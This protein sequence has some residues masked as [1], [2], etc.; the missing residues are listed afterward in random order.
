MDRYLNGKTT[1]LG[2]ISIFLVL[3]FTQAL[4]DILSVVK[5]KDNTTNET[6]ESHRVMYAITDN[7]NKRLERIDVCITSI[8]KTLASS[9]EIQ[10]QQGDILRTQKELLV[11]YKYILEEVKGI[12]VEL[13]RAKG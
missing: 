9:L 5:G 12:L 10:R 2:I 1:A 6:M 8:D 13:K 11:N 4:P 7:I 3:F